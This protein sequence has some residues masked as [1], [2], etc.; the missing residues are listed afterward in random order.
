MSN[1]YSDNLILF[2][3]SYKHSHHLLYPDGTTYLK[4]YTESRGGDWDS[5]VFFGLQYFLKEYLTRRISVDNVHQARDLMNRHFGRDI[6][7]VDAWHTIATELDGRLPIRI[8]AVAEGTVVPTHNLLLSVE[9]TDTR[10][11]WIASWVETMLL[12]AAWYGTTVATQS[13]NIKQIILSYLKQTSDNPDAE[14]GF[15]LHD[16]GARG[17]SSHESAM[18][19]GLAHLVNFMGS[20][21]IEGICCGADYYNEPLAA[22]SIPASEHSTMCMWFR[23]G[24]V[25]AF[26]NMLQKYGGDGKIFACVSDTYDIFNATSNLWGGVLREEVLKSGSTVVIRPDSGDD[27]PGIVLEIIQRLDEKFGH[28]INHKG[29]KVL[30]HVRVIQGDGINQNS[31]KQILDRIIEN[32]YSASNIAFGMGGALL[33]KGLD[34]DTLN[35]AHKACYGIVNGKTREIYKDPITGN[36]K[37]SK[38]GDLDLYLENGLLTTKTKENALGLES[39]TRMVF[40]QG[41]LI[42][43]DSLSAIRSRVSVGCL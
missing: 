5:T 17:V 9:S 36:W 13:Y 34:R 19:G 2:C 6:F 24:E 41:N 26:R 30:E 10:F 32:N 40:E 14:I 21:T 16:F 33:Q 42:V 1:K 11:P 4:G 23:E 28:I 35:F 12:R 29:Y 37:K 3:D 18:I 38:K 8:R 31:I 25:D 20:D 7:P 22:Y 15:K 39:Q 27:I 43:D